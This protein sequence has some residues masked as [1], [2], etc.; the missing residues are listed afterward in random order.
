MSWQRATKLLICACV[1]VLIVYDIFV[2]MHSGVDATISRVVL[3]WSRQWPVLPFSTGV[4]CGHLFWPQK[5][6][7]KV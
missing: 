4:V 2:Y 6:D 5:Q 1:A 7:P 3:R